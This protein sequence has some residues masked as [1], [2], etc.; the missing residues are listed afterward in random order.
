[1]IVNST[2]VYLCIL[3]ILVHLAGFLRMDLQIEMRLA[4][5]TELWLG[6][7][8]CLGR[9]PSVPELAYPGESGVRVICIGF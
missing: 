1:M 4:S 2:L 5:G 9:V 6:E 3:N 8:A 7:S